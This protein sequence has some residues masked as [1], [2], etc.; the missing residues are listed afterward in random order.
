MVPSIAIAFATYEMVKDVLG[1]EMGISNW[2]IS[3]SF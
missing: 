2:R 1:V 3:I